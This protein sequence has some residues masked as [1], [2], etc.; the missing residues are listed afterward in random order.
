MFFNAINPIYNCAS[1]QRSSQAS[2]LFS[3]LSSL[4]SAALNCKTQG[5]RARCLKTHQ[6]QDLITTTFARPPRPRSKRLASEA[7][8]SCLPTWPP[9]PGGGQTVTNVC[10]QENKR[11]RDQ[12]NKTKVIK[13][14]GTSRAKADD[15]KKKTF[16]CDRDFGCRRSPNETHYF[17]RRNPG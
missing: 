14:P 11:K 9:P 2:S 17:L 5:F 7:G 3:L 8:A 1:D 16:F 13:R 6:G 12:S 15:N 10:T 4:F